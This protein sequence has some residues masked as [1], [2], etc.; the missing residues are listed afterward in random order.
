MR[1]ASAIHAAMKLMPRGYHAGIKMISH[2]FIFAFQRGEAAG[3]RL[4]TWYRAFAGTP[5]QGA[6]LPEIEDQALEP[7]R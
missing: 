1:I 3:I 7:A 5:K 4:P 2:K 6:T